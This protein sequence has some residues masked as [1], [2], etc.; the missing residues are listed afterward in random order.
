MLLLVSRF[1]TCSQQFNSFSLTPLYFNLKGLFKHLPFLNPRSV[2]FTPSWGK[3]AAVSDSGE[4]EAD[5]FKALAAVDQCVAQE[6]YVSYLVQRLR[7]SSR[8]LI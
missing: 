8:I 1:P 6:Q 5:V 3:R 7:V 2:N 4:A